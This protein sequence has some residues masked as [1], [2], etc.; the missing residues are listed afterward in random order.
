MKI[1]NEGD[2]EDMNIINNMDYIKMENE[3][4]Y[5]FEKTD[6]Y[7]EDKERIDTIKKIRL[8]DNFYK[9]FRNIFKIQINKIINYEFKKEILLMVENLEYDY[10][11]KMELIKDKI[12]RLLSDEYVEF[13]DFKEMD[14]L[15]LEKVLG[16]NECGENEQCSFSEEEKRKILIPKKNILNENN[17]EEVYYK[18][19]SDEIIRYY[20]IRKY[21]FSNRSYLSFEHIEYNITDQEVILLE[22]VLENYLQDLIVQKK[23]I[24]IKSISKYDNINVNNDWKPINNYS[25]QEDKKIMIKKAVEKVEKVEKKRK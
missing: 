21:I 16:L 25:L 11:K 15:E 10:L 20:K 7:K 23:N 24:Y 8:E 14:V 9:M 4:M 22:E 1:Y 5:N 3:T 19:L 18:K 13:V 6:E 2:E 12:E 17:N